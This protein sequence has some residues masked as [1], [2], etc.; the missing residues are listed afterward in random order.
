MTDE[1]NIKF[2]IEVIFNRKKTRVSQIY[3]VILLTLNLVGLMIL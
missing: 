3:M 1:S 2:A